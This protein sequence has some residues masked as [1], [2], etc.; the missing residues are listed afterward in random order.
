[1]TKI[2]VVV[3]D[4]FFENTKMTTISK[5]IQ[6]HLNKLLDI[7]RLFFNNLT[8]VGRLPLDPVLPILYKLCL[9]MLVSDSWFLYKT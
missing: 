9:Q 2:N 4:L 7:Q 5:N 3:E 1:M 6:V 8:Q